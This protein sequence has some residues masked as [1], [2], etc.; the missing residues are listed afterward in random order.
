M[1]ARAFAILPLALAGG[2]T[3]SGA[4]ALQ[5]MCVAAATGA[6]PRNNQTTTATP[7][8]ALT[9]VTRCL[10]TSAH[11]K[12]RGHLTRKNGPRLPAPPAGCVGLVYWLHSAWMA[13][14]TCRGC[15]STETLLRSR[16]VIPVR[17]PWQRTVAAGPQ[18][19][20]LYA[21]DRS[22][23]RMLCN[24]YFVR[25]FVARRSRVQSRIEEQHLASS[26][27]HCIAIAI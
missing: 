4:L 14:V 25:S 10:L 12:S 13:A 11:E 3:R 2:A 16:R 17:C 6:P 8:V 1:A 23:G 22:V 24:T 26:M 18:G 7:C 27:Q 5:P 9:K 21:G 20:A 19:L 15:Q